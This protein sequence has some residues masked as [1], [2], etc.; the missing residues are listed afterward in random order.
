MRTSPESSKM[1]LSKKSLKMLVAKMTGFCRN[2]RNPAMSGVISHIRMS[3][4]LGRALV[5]NKI[6]LC[7]AFI[8]RAGTQNKRACYPRKPSNHEVRPQ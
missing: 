6:L 5:T 8:I 4:I 7:A 2:L 1:C 3:D